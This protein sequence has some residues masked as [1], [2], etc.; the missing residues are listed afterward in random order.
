M[1]VLSGVAVLTM[2]VPALALAQ[3]PVDE[4]GGGNGSR[5]S[6][7]VNV[8][9]VRSDVSPQGQLLQQLYQLQ[10]E[11]SMLRGMLEEQEHRISRME[12]DQQTRYED[13]DRRLQA[14]SGSSG[15]EPDNNAPVA[16]QPV[17]PQVTDQLPLDTNEAVAEPDPEREKLLYEA[18]Y[19]QVRQRNFTQAIAAYNAFLRRYPESDYAGNAQYWLGELYLAESDYTASEQA[20]QRVLSRYPGHRKEADTLYKLG[21]VERRR[22]N[23]AQA[24]EWFQRVLAEYPNSSAAQLARRDMANLN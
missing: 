11:V 10:Q 16:E 19:D 17:S 14:V 23:N 5:S 13:I 3:V 4:R 1:R 24:R 9:Q 18:A 15:P 12:D 6:T 21:D 2:L 22:E 20:F 7:A 8:P